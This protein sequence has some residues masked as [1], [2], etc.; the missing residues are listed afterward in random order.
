MNIE[1]GLEKAE[2]LGSLLGVHPDTTLRILVEFFRS[3][4][5]EE[6]SDDDIEWAIGCVGG[7]LRHLATERGLK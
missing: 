5:T 6:N 3:V 4:K 2:A 1:T 7:S